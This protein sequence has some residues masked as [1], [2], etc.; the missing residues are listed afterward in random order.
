MTRWW[1][2]VPPRRDCFLVLLGEPMQRWVA[3]RW[4]APLHYIPVPSNP[5]TSP[6]R[7]TLAYFHNPDYRLHIPHPT[8]RRMTVFE[9][10]WMLFDRSVSRAD[11]RQEDEQAS[12]VA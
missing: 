5:I 3:D 9:H 1:R 6:A 4:F 10:W 7:L 12:G 11:D 8:K 2:A